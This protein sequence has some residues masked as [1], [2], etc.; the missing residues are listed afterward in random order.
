[1]SHRPLQFDRQE[2]TRGGVKSSAL[3][4][5]EL[6]DLLNNF[7]S[8]AQNA[9][10]N[11]AAKNVIAA[12]P[13]DKSTAV[14]QLDAAVFN[15]PELTRLPPAAALLRVETDQARVGIEMNCVSAAAASAGTAEAGTAEARDTLAYRGAAR[16]DR[17]LRVAGPAKVEMLSTTVPPSP[18][19]HQPPNTPAKL[20][21]Q[22]QQ[23]DDELR[24]MR[25]QQLLALQL[26]NQHQAQS[27]RFYPRDAVADAP[28][29]LISSMDTAHLMA[30]TP[31]ADLSHLGQIDSGLPR[32]LV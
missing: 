17:L 25:Q 14:L 16:H 30:L 31:R 8:G 32:F 12:A 23:Y 9:L 24:F 20:S 26:Q 5:L 15:L 22:Q 6:P 13:F 19:K 4:T 7:R 3:P 2:N 28:A 21:E 11:K 10:E 29:R 18:M 1:M 27:A